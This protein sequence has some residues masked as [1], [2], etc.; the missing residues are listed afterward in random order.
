MGL[1]KEE[2]GNEEICEGIVESGEG[3]VEKE[4]EK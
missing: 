4:E 1:D 3:T 2:I